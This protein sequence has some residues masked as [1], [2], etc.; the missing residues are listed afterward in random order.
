MDAE[1]R[2]ARQIAKEPDMPSYTTISKWLTRKREKE[3]EAQG[4]V[5]PTSQALNRVVTPPDNPE[6]TYHAFGPPKRAEDSPVV[7]LSLTRSLVGMF[8]SPKELLDA[9]ESSALPPNAWL[10]A[11]GRVEIRGEGQEPMWPSYGPPEFAKNKGGTRFIK[12]TPEA[13]RPAHRSGVK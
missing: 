5:T 9:K 6:K 7:K 3:L 4:V 11:W 2:S 13:Q 10:D 1:G 8:L 12:L